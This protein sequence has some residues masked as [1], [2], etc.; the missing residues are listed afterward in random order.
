MEEEC[1]VEYYYYI[2]ARSVTYAQRMR[3]VLEAA[4]IR[5]RVFRAPRELTD[6]GCAYVLR[7]APEDL[8]QAVELLRREHLAPYR[9]FLYRNGVYREVEL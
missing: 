9:V 2:F 4:G 7:L 6:R 5:S 3:R 8:S 1:Q